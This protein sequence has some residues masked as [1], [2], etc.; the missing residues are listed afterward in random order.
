MPVPRSARRNEN[1]FGAG[2]PGD[3][4]LAKLWKKPGRSLRSR[5]RRRATHVLP[6]KRSRSEVVSVGWA[7]RRQKIA[8][9]L[10]P[11]NAESKRTGTK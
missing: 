1:H 3:L 10:V 6:E 4:G 9:Q 8:S 2:R 7:P 5:A 11:T